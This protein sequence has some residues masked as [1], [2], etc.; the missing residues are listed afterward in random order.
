MTHGPAHIGQQASGPAQQHMWKVNNI[1]DKNNRFNKLQTKT[2]R[3]SGA[4]LEMKSQDTIRQ[5]YS[6]IEFIVFNDIYHSN[7][8]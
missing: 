7:K 2:I 3:K 8:A 6:H 1:T 5:G 4:S